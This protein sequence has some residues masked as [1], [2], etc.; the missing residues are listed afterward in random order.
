MN[1]VESGLVK[2]R[3]KGRLDCNDI[4][5]KMLQF[6]ED[7]KPGTYLNKIVSKILNH[8]HSVLEIHF[9][10][11]QTDAENL[12]CLSEPTAQA[13]Y[14][15]LRLILT[16][17]TYCKKF[18]GTT[19]TKF[20]RLCMPSNLRIISPLSSL[21]FCLIITCFRYDRF[22]LEGKSI[23][24][25]YKKEMKYSCDLEFIFCVCTNWFKLIVSNGNDL[26]LGNRK[27]YNNG[28][29]A[30]ISNNLLQTL[31]ALITEYNINVITSLLNFGG[32]H[33]FAFAMSHVTDSFES[34][35]KSS[36]CYLICYYKVL[37][38]V[39]NWAGIQSNLSR[40]KSNA[41]ICK[42][43]ILSQIKELYENLL[44]SNSLSTSL[45]QSNI[46]RILS[47]DGQL[48]YS[49]KETVDQHLE[50]TAQVVAIYAILT[51]EDGLKY[52]STTS[53]AHHTNT[54]SINVLTHRED[55]YKTEPK[56]QK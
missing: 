27:I 51:S 10:H 35:R 5:T 22:L 21:L 36:L 16:S 6:C 39:T 48:D 50:L 11:V 14:K 43:K 45:A 18:K 53:S 8:V 13:Y 15:A 49:Q 38:R 47:C 46:Q 24:T 4:V 56:K 7:R 3:S 25:M 34:L 33:V 30:D 44:R 40:S 31:I 54:K 9:Q 32:N 37:R 23:A 20:V 41:D 19:F 26:K 2:F 28:A 12:K 42:A 29:I 1:S 52:N 17:K 55:C